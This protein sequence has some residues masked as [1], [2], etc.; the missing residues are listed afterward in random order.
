MAS[1]TFDIAAPPF[2]DGKPKLLFIDGKTTPAQ[3]GVTFQTIN[4]TTGTVLA[5]VAEADAGDVDRAVAAARRAL[6]GPWARFKP[7]DR[8]QVMLRLG[9]LVEKHYDE[10]AMLD[11]LDMMA[12]AFTS[13]LWHRL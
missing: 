2:L 7:F 4:P 3:A 10:L 1:G 9:D 5:E 8:Q 11:T 13:L 6:E 12:I